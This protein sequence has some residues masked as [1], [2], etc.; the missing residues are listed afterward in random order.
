MVAAK[1]TLKE[2]SVRPMEDI[3]SLIKQLEAPDVEARIAAIRELGEQGAEARL[4]YNALMNR[5]RVTE[6]PKELQ[7]L[8]VTLARL[9][10]ESLDVAGS[11]RFVR[12]EQDSCRKLVQVPQRA[13]SPR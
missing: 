8:R 11:L 9:D 7:A 2:R 12:Q 10:P 6:D 3:D 4:A 13:G 1:V 5:Y